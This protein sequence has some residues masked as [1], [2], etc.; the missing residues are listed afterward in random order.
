MPFSSVRCGSA[1]FIL[2]FILDG[3]DIL[4]NLAHAADPLFNL[5]RVIQM[6]RARENSC[7]QRS[8]GDF[9]RVFDLS[10][11]FHCR[12]RGLPSPQATGH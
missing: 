8:A 2:L 3:V 11:V 5:I 7:A 4:G 6:I 12:S 10:R 9:S 1:N